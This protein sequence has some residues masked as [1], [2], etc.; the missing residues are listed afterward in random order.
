LAV[1]KMRIRLAV[2]A[3][4]PVTLGLAL[5]A[6]LPAHAAAITHVAAARAVSPPDRLADPGKVLGPG[7]QSSADR[8]VTVAGDATGLHVLMADASAGYAWRTV[9]TLGVRGTDTSQWIGQACV[10]GSGQQA[11]VVYAPRQ[12]TNSPD[13]LGFGALAAVVNLSTGAVRQLGAGVSIAYFDPGC[14]TDQDAVLTQGGTGASPL[15]GPE[16]TRLMTVD[17][18]TAKITSMVTEPGQLTSAVPFG[19]GVAAVRGGSV[20][21]VT[22]GGRIGV[23]AAVPGQAYRLAPDGNG[24]LGFLVASGKQVQVRRWIAGQDELVGSA[25]LGSVELAQTGGRV[26][27]TGDQASRLGRMPAGWQALDVTSGADVSSTGKLAVSLATAGPDAKARSPLAAPPDQPQPVHITAQATTTGAKLT[28]TAPAAQSSDAVVVPSALPGYPGGG[29]GQAARR[30]SAARVAAPSVN[31]PPSNVNPATPT[32]D[33]DR[34]C[35]VPRNDPNIQ[36]YQPSAAQV[37]W[38]VDEAVQYALTADQPAN[39]DGSGLP[40]YSPQG[41]FPSPGLTGG[42]RVPAQVLLG[43]L[44]QESNEY[45]ASGHAIIGQ[46][47]NFEPSSNWYGD[48][49]NYTSVDFAASDCGYGIAQVTSNMCLAGYSGCTTAAPY[50]DQL[51]VAVDYEAN[52]AAGLRILEQKWNQLYS[53]GILANGGNP[54]YV[55]N[56]WFALWA[57]NSGLQPSTANGNTLGCSPSP[58]CTDASGNGPGGNWG[59]GWVNN[60][61]NPLYPPDRPMFLERPPSTGSVYSYAYDE[62]HPGLWSYE[63]KVIGFA[64]YGFYPY[65]YVQGANELAFAQ[66]NYPGLDQ[67]TNPTVP[68]PAQ[69]PISKFCADSGTDNNHCNPA[70]AGSSGACLLSNDHC[71]WHEPITWAT[72][73]SV[74]GVQALTYAA[75]V[76]NPGDPGVPSGYGPKCSASPLPSNA[77][78]VGNVPS[79][80]PAP[81]GCGASWSNNGG[82]MSWNFG[83]AGVSPTTYPSKIDFHQIGDG[84][85]GHYWF[86]HTI[87]SDQVS[88]TVP[89]GTTPAQPQLEVTGTWKPP[90]SV[91]GWTKIMVSIPNEGAWDPQANYQIHLGNGTTQYRIVNQ[92]YQTDTWI[93]LGSYD[94]ASGASVSL[95]N[96]TYSGLRYD[97]AWDAVAFIPSSAPGADY[98]ALGDSYSSGEGLQPFDPNAD[99]NYSGMVDTCHRSGNFGSG[100]A[101]AAKVT[102]PGQSTPIASQAKNVTSTTHFMFLA[103]SGDYTT[104]AAIQAYDTSVSGGT[105]SQSAMANTVWHTFQLG[106]NEL[107]QASEGWL[108]PQTTLITLTAGG[109]DARF[110]SV[111]VGCLLTTGDCTDTNFYMKDNATGVLDPKPL[112]QYEPQVINALQPHLVALFKALATAAPHAE[113]VVLGY[114]RLFPGDT[115]APSCNVSVSGYQVPVIGADVTSWLN[116]MGDLLNE[117]INL[118][119]QAA[120]GAGYNV[121]F[122][123][124]SNYFTGHEIC[125]SSPWI[126]AVIAYSE[127]G[128]DG[129]KIHVPGAG[130]FHPMA[131]GQQEFATLVDSCLARTSPC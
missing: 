107:P 75:G 76:A 108:G 18:A 73:A 100:Q 58:S 115:S 80:I 106:S 104:Q 60:P 105:V 84:Y 38:A 70:S 63:E 28:F 119:A 11:V 21:S 78:I 44:A 49:G 17:T 93:D 7:W 48:Q 68:V 36:T 4:V 39:L 20:V 47:G 113:I 125:S 82:T 85:S 92:A 52:I 37:E 91:S 43:I 5:L 111:V 74:C 127:S 45:Q 61:S 8:A 41:M 30:A 40:A 46:T 123:D 26:F 94:L 83:A 62:A 24:G 114:P 9:A 16:T 42:G 95:N 97:V 90:S 81:L 122:I 34:S 71:W 59:L 130:S 51:A 56:W 2:A 89:I 6:Q 112:Y 96:V 3:C 124:P 98:V 87:T 65:N 101:Y 54:N 88:P 12:I 79:S 69:P 99:Y 103:C 121:H 10:T 53:L 102:L 57:Y 128:S 1:I 66:T 86:T 35:S 77:V 14:G 32:Y 29:N 117:N 22:S 19:G 33:P 72:C 50:E 126:N 131:A 118:A 67:N 110:S 120:I 25:P 129:G 23:L 116:E 64:A 15:P 109:D 27:V 55:E 31:P 13:A